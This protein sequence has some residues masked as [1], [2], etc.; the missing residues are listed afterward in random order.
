MKIIYYELLIKQGSQL[1]AKKVILNTFISIKT[2]FLLLIACKLFLSF[3]YKLFGKSSESRLLFNLF[4]NYLCLSKRIFNVLDAPRCIITKNYYSYFNYILRCNF[5]MHQVLPLV[6]TTISQ[7]AL[8]FNYLLY[9][10]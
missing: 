8:P 6:P 3:C 10:F 7:K 4:C 9:V 5:F 2:P 1:P